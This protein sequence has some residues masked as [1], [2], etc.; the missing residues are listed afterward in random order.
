M[1]Q[2]LLYQHSQLFFRLFI[3]IKASKT[4]PFRTE[5][6][7]ILGKTGQQLCP[8][9]AI[10]L[11]VAVRGAQDGPLFRFQDGS[12]LTHDRFVVEVRR[13]LTAA[14]IDPEPYSGYSFSIGAATTAAYA[15]MNATLIQTLGRWKSSAY[16]LY[17]RIPKDSLASVSTALAAVP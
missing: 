17:I 5:T 8:L 6:I 4:D 7:I 9:T 14:G 2:S 3:T 10:L 16:Q 12:F 11:Y 13:L 1:A 15:G